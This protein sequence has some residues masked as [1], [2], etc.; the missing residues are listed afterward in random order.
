MDKLRH[1]R[2]LRPNHRNHRR[3]PPRHRR[4]PQTK[5]PLHRSLRQRLQRL[6][7]R[8][9][10]PPAGALATAVTQKKRKA[11]DTPSKKEKQ[12]E[13]EPVDPDTGSST[14]S[15][16]T[17]GLLPNPFESKGAKFTL[18]YVADGLANLAGG[19]QRGAVYEGRLNAAVDLDLAKL[20]GASGL[21]F[22]ANAFQSHGPRLS[23]QDIGNI[24]P[25]SSV[26][27]LATTRLYGAWFTKVLERQYSGF[28]PDKRGGRRVHHSPIHRSFHGRDV[29]MADD[30]LR[31]FTKRR[32]VA[33]ARGYGR[34]HE[35]DPQ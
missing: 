13:H 22:H 19:L 7:P 20:V 27:E 11:A 10:C 4:L 30:H 9:Q 35:G 18:T 28:V 17:L 8:R 6:R 31:R 1:H 25:V 5:R 29:W 34:T 33:S 2:P 26:E 32:P 21:T 15:G 14:L 3:Q 24:M 16:D 12:E 23:A